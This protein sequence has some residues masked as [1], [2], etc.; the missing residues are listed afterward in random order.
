MV[1]TSRQGPFLRNSDVS[2][3][4]SK[5]SPFNCVRLCANSDGGGH[6]VVANSWKLLV[7]RYNSLVRVLHGR[8]AASAGS[9][10][11][12]K[13]ESGLLCATITIRL[14]L[15]DSGPNIPILTATS[16]SYESEIKRNANPATVSRCYYSTSRIT[17]IT[18]LR[19]QGTKVIYS[20]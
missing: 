9:A 18:R 14:H 1:K 2:Y 3:P 15:G 19:S 10:G 12:P 4:I 11:P 13:A 17:R 20:R 6:C 16:A 7:Q 5:L 8:A